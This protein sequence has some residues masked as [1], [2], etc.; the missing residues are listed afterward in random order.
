MAF[1]TENE[2]V[3]AFFSHILLGFSVF[4]FLLCFV[5]LFVWFLFVSAI[6]SST[7]QMNKHHV[8]IWYSSWVSLHFNAILAELQIYCHFYR[9]WRLMH[10]RLICRVILLLQNC[11]LPLKNLTKAEVRSEYHFSCFYIFHITTKIKSELFSKWQC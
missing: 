11:T 5:C 9:Y 8:D 10:C 1:Q 4:C 7:L 2:H 6:L 3:Y